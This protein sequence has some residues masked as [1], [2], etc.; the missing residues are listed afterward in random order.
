M[1]KI[2]KLILTIPVLLLGLFVVS[3]VKAIDV[4]TTV[5]SNDL[6]GNLADVMSNPTKW[7][8]YNDESDVIDNT[9][10]SFVNGPATAPL[11]LGSAQIG[12]TGTQR[13]NL[14]TY[15]FSGVPLSSI[16]VLKYSTYNPS[17][18]NPGSVNKSGYLQFNVDFNGTDAWQKR[19][20]FVPSQNG[21]VTQ[22]NWKEWDAI[23]SGN[24]KWWWSGFVANGNKWPDNNTNEYRT[25]SDLLASFPSI[26][27][28]VTDS[29]LGIRVGEPYPDGY[30]ENIDKFVFGTSNGIK[31]FDFE[32]GLRPANPFPVPAQCNQNISY[33]L[34]EGKNKSERINGTNGND[35][36]Y[37][38]GGSDTINGNG[39]NDC[40][41]GGIGADTINGNGGDDVILGGG[42]A[43][44][45][46]G[47][48]NS[49]TL[50]GEGAADTLRG[51]NGN[52]FLYGG[53]AYDSA[54]GESG[55]DT[56]IAESKNSC[57]L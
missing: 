41:V 19:I 22:D 5:Y 23:N 55:S 54:R 48:D 43:D 25:W 30:T 47:G 28:R 7:F 3:P 10:G 45:L 17:A 12:V 6:A 16:T 26:R 49:D 27:I 29:F 56:C 14:A 46:N 4:T 13:R 51:G 32:P 38:N 37:G 44:S 24:A 18:G 33:N 39:G 34:I 57:E 35:L 53:D 9:L 40:I 31:T 2:K 42:G 36:I 21:V 50:Y 20:A 1:I 11:G 8:F 52:D 15:Q